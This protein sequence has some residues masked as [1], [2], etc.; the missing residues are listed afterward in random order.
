[1]PAARVVR[2]PVGVSSQTPSA[3]RE[4]VLRIS[5]GRRAVTMVRAG[6][7]SPIAEPNAKRGPARAVNK[8]GL[9][10]GAP[11]WGSQGGENEGTRG[12]RPFTVARIIPSALNSA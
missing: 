12:H 6:N 5:Q 9:R 7:T 4:A 11:R 8:R 3:T 1:R 2:A 10:E